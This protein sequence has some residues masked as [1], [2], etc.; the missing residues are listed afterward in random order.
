MLIGRCYG[1]FFTGSRDE[2][3]GTGCERSEYAASTPFGD[4]GERISCCAG[5]MSSLLWFKTRSRKAS[6][7]MSKILWSVIHFCA[8]LW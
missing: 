6:K 3:P 1:F 8:Q 7:S 2:S 5:R 4:K